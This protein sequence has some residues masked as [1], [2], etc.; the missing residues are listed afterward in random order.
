MLF[1]AFLAYCIGI[2]LFGSGYLL[3]RNELADRQ[4]CRLYAPLPQQQSSMPTAAAAEPKCWQRTRASSSDR[5]GQEQPQTFERAVVLIIDAL[6]FD[7]VVPL[8]PS[9]SSNSS[10]SAASSA[11]SVPHYRNKLPVISRLLSSQPANS[12]LLRARSDP[13]TTTMQRLKAL[14]TGTLP[15]FVDAGSNFGALAI[16]ED[17][18]FAQLRQHG[19][20]LR[21]VKGQKIF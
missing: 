10:N 20:R 17:N 15:T 12:L 6:R 11:S 9:S 4:E 3:T 7:F 16:T 1:L 2:F 8:S 14:S 19:W 13:P 5:G 18:L 21:W